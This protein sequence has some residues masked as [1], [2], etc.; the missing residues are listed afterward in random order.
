MEALQR[1]IVQVRRQ[2]AYAWAKYYETLNSSLQQDRRQHE[3]I[4]RIVSEDSIPEHIKTELKT[5]AT[6]LH[7]KWECPVCLEMID[8]G[9]LEITNCGHFYCKTCLQ[10]HIETFKQRGETKYNC[11]VCR[12]NINIKDE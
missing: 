6:T 8:D 5:M 9:D 4:T 1:T 3:R 11:C 12:R 10:T 7:K 2:K